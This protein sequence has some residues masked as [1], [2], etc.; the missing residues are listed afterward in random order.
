MFP[1]S[2]S[3]SVRQRF[4]VWGGMLLVLAILLLATDLIHNANLQGFNADLS[5]TTNELKTGNV[6]PDDAKPGDAKPGDAAITE[7]LTEL[8]NAMLS[9]A[10]SNSRNKMMLALLIVFVFAQMI[11]L[12]YRW[13]VKPIIGMS[14]TFDHLE[15][16]IAKPH[17]QDS[18][19]SASMRRDEVGNLGRVLLRYVG[20]IAVEKT[21]TQ[22]TMLNLNER[23]SEQQEIEKTNEA[24]RTAI[25]AIVTKLEDH[26][27]QMSHASSAL[28]VL[29]SDMNARADETAEVIEQASSQVEGMAISINDFASSILNMSD[30]SMAASQSA[31]AAKEFAIVA[32][33]DT[34]ELREAVVMIEEMVQLVSNVAN[35]TNLLALNATIEAARA[36]E[37]GRGFAVV[38]SE[39]KQLAQ[40]TSKATSDAGDRLN[41]IRSA[42]DRISNR[43]VSVA[44]SVTDI[45]KVASEIAESMRKEGENSRVISHEITTT[46]NSVLSGAEKVKQVTNLVKD[47]DAAAASLANVSDALTNQADALRNT[48]KA[49]IENDRKR[50]A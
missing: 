17:S 28:T 23:L 7:K 5:K 42:A 47:S 49:F 43:I 24:F 22:Q 2:F 16:G 25:A 36:G 20:N 26:A 40:Q 12:E 9:H 10:A 19:R 1:N 44:S 33:D 37:N 14:R 38:A 39:V 21:T 45:S 13:L 32:Q 41:A 6:K 46:A 30:Q 35:Q 34:R 8:H 11:Y 3:A 48:V 15:S 31:K 18:L 27:N 29:S 50:A 4:Y